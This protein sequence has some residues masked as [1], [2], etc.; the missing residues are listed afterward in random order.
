MARGQ[1]GNKGGQVIH[2]TFVLIHFTVEIIHL[3][4]VVVYYFTQ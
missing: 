1:R 2:S 3:L 4:F